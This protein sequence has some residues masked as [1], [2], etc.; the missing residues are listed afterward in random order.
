MRV[1][2]SPSVR[3]GAAASCVC[4]VCVRS[5]TCACFCL[6]GWLCPSVCLSLCLSRSLSRS[7][8]LSRALSLFSSSLRRTRVFLTHTW[9]HQ[10]CGERRFGTD[11]PAPET[12]PQTKRILRCVFINTVANDDFELMGQLDPIVQVD[13]SL[14][15]K[16]DILE[17]KPVGAWACLARL[18]IHIYVLNVC[19]YVCIHTYLHMYT[20]IYLHICI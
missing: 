2:E 18:Y 17:P 5:C 7:L 10:R 12:N 3:P 20:Y 1:S 16:A 4:D 13:S 9:F 14:N 11:G 15:P 8:S 19:M 6:S